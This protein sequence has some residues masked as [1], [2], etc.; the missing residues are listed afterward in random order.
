MTAFKVQPPKKAVDPTKLAAFTAGADTHQPAGMLPTGSEG[1]AASVDR[2]TESLLFR[3]AR[4]DLDTFNF[5]FE[6][7][8]VK[9]KQK[10]LEAIILP[11]IRRRA[12]AIKA[13]E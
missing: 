13:N 8:N 5:V 6:H 3:L 9:S 2:H 4:A 10:L 11:D 1:A 12:A 7:T